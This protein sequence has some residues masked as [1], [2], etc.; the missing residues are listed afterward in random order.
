M[1]VCLCVKTHRWFDRI[2]TSCI[3]WRVVL[4]SFLVPGKDIS[5]SQ[6]FIC[7][8]FLLGNRHISTH[9]A[10]VKSLNFTST[11]WIRLYSYVHLTFGETEAQAISV[12]C[13][14]SLC[15]QAVEM[16]LG[17]RLVCGLAFLSTAHSVPPLQGDY[18]LKVVKTY[19]TPPVPLSPAPLEWPGFLFLLEPVLCFIFFKKTI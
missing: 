5:S 1:F 10:W 14:R 11:L 16:E 12:A 18:P 19:A 3:E 17:L 4:L 6:Q 8:E 2:L 13:P 7:L 9:F 15:W